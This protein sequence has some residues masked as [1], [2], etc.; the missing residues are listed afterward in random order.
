MPARRRRSSSRPMGRSRR[1]LVWATVDQSLS[2]AAATNC[3]NVDLLTALKVTGSSILGCTIMR[4]RLDL[5][6][7]STVALAD[8]FY[9]GLAI[10]PNAQLVSNVAS[11]ATVVNP[12]QNPEIDWMM[13]AH[14]VAA[15]TYGTTANDNQI[16]IDIR[17]KRRLQ[18]LQE[19]YCFSLRGSAGAAF[20]AQ[21]SGRV[22]VALP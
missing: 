13:W 19:T 16:V 9:W 18:E 22:L 15:P 17:A 5:S 1:Q 14:A 21:L 12:A 11:S 4:T 7:T 20:T 6:I 3:S 10:L 8:N 2:L